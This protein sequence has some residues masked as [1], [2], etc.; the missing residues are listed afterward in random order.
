MNKKQRI[1]LADSSRFFRTIETKFLQKTPIEVLEASDEQ[2]VLSLVRN[3]GPDLIYMAYDLAVAGDPAL[4]LRLKN[5]P[6]TSSLPIVV[7]CDQGAPE[8]TKVVRR[9]EADA[10]LVKP[11]DRHSFLQIG[12]KYLSSIREHRQPSFFPLSFHIDNE[13]HQG[14]CLDISGGGMFIESHV[15]VLAGTALKLAFLLHDGTAT[16]IDCQAVVTWLNRKPNPI[17]PHYPFGFG[18]KFAELSDVASRTIQRL[19]NKMP[20][21]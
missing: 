14:K 11:L 21:R 18:I 5:N 12:R 20:G 7:I 4:C 17:K 16:H 8:Q 6:A 19:I 2:D 15:D 1:L 3:E 13:E 9:M 10:C